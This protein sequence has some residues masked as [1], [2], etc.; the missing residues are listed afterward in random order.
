M[1]AVRSSLSDKRVLA[2]LIAILAL[3]SVLRFCGLDAK[4]L[5][6]DE[7]S[8]WKRSGYG[9]LYTVI[10][11]GVR[12]GSHPPGYLTF[13]HVVQE[14]LGDSELSL[15]LP[16]A[17]GGVLSI[18]VV[19]LVG[20]GLYSY[21]EGLIASTLMAVL[22][23]PVY[24]SQ[25]ARPYS[26]LLLSTLSATYLWIL[27]LESLSEK[28]S[29]PRWPVFGY[30]V[31]A[32]VCSYVH[33]FGLYF[34][35]LQAAGAVLFLAR[36]PRALLRILAVYLIILV[37]YLPWLPF[38]LEDVLAGDTWIPR[39]TR[40]VFVSFA[41]FLKFLF[42]RSR[43]L[44]L[45]VL[46]LYSFLLMRTLYEV[47]RRE[48]RDSVNMNLLSPGL[49]LVSWLIVPFTGAYVKCMVSFSVLT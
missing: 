30:I 32:A 2:A 31:A 14:Y 38:M 24:Y 21:K 20:L 26:L 5:W 17:L 39:P 11:K 19:F 47:Y 42:N 22:W 15:R 49:L 1:D 6:N 18:L 29:L 27:V 10:N 37:A 36:R 7:L 12:P 44:L 33:H 13:L 4:S 48:K 9:D 43:V 45:L 3:G 46:M 25:Q 40:N 35:A 16:S 41:S 34:I 23:C 28:G 8:A